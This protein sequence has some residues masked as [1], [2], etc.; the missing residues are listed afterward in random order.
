MP[1]D[2]AAEIARLREEIRYHDR[3]Y[4]IEAAP[5]ISDRQYDRLV[6][7]LKKLEAEHPRL[8]APDSPT[9]RVGDRPVR[10][11]S[12]SSIACRCSR[13]TIPTASTS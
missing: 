8:V 12:R 5:E 3:K 1:T 7:R 2:P 9:Q 6:G 4:H 11:S 10:G 13:S